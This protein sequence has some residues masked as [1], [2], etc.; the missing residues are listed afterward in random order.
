M[1]FFH[2][3][4]CSLILLLQTCLQSLLGALK[5]DAVP[6]IKNGAEAFSEAQWQTQKTTMAKT[7]RMGIREITK[8][9]RPFIEQS[10]LDR[11][12]SLLLFNMCVWL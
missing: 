7:Y 4:F 9:G 5:G 3:F 6:I 8:A 10:E 2:G 12:W 11:V 1:M